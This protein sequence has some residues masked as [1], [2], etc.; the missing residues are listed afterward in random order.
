M[1]WRNKKGKASAPKKDLTKLKT[2]HTYAIIFFV[3]VFCWV[4][5]FLVPAGKFSTHTIEYTDANGETATRTVLMADTFRYSYNLD[6]D[7]VAGA[8][9]E[10]S[11]DPELMEELEV[12]PEALTAL[13]ETDSSAW[14]QE[15]LDAAGLSDD[16]MYSLYGEEFY[17]TS[18]KLHKTAGVWGTEDF[19]GFGFLNYVF[20][21]LVSGDRSGTA[22]GICALIL[23]I[24]GAFGIIM[25]TGA[26]DAGIYAFINKTKGLERLALP[27]LFILF[28]LGG[29]TFGMAE[30]CIPFAMIM[31]PFV[32]ALG[33]DSIVAVT[34][35]YVASQVGN[36]VSWMSPFSVAVAQ[37]IAGVPVLSGATFRMVMWVVVTL[38][39]D[40]FMM[41]Y[42]ER[43]RKN[44]QKSVVYAGDAYFRDRLDM[45][46]EEEREFNLGHKLI[47]L[48][49]AAVM[50]WIVWG[51]T[52]KGFYIPEIASQFF[53]M[54]F[55]AGVIAII[56][57]LNGMTVNG[58]ASAFQGG[59]SDLAGT[60]VVVGMAKGILLVLGGS[61]ADVPSTL[62]T[63]LHVIG[64]ALDGVPAFIGAW[65]M[66][67]FQSLF[68]LV[69]TSNSGQ[70]AL[71]MPI[72]APLSD[73]V[74][75]SRQ[76]AVLAYQLGAGF[77][78]AFTPVSASLIGVLGVAR[79]EWGKWAKFQIKMQAFFFLLGTIFIAIAVAINFQ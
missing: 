12:D 21:G 36:A 75:V 69:V 29:A 71:T 34:V 68:N 72:M 52:Q 28:S 13:M 79:I 77:V 50:I 20:E 22:V 5:T 70:A 14:T 44:P 15:D 3:V 19:G 1:L 66:Y 46:T 55:V 4:L 7:F 35:T 9:E 60:A 42:A 6:T 2:P 8:L 73:L 76:I 48:E 37:G 67:L 54:G 65:F 49:M 53:V 32:I 58:M 33:Y 18:R 41:V 63:V 24:G 64:T 43:V 78:D 10:I 23:V 38:A 56:F 57:K 17:D 30:E 74:G 62:N 25:K 39:A 31:V 27:L 40:A 47:L 11:R 51:V 16:E 26:I 59:V 61:D 45:V